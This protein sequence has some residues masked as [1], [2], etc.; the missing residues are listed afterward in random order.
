ML[1]IKMIRKNP[2]LV[3]KEISKLSGDH[4]IDK[5]IELDEKRRNLLVEVEE[6][7]A[8]QNQVSKE[9]PKMKKEGKD[10]SELLEEMKELSSN[11]KDIDGEVKEIDKD[12]KKLLLGIPNIP[13]ESVPEGET[14]EDNVE[15]RK[16]GQPTEFSFEPKAH[17]D[18]GVE[19]NILDFERA[20]KITGTRFSIFRNKGAL[21]QRALI[22][23]MLD[24]H[25]VDQDYIEMLTPFMVNRSSMTGTGQLPKFEEDAFSIPSKD[26]FLVP[27]A[28]VPVTNLHRDE[29]LNEDILPTYY[30]AY[31]PC[32]RQEAGSAGRDTR[33]LIRNHQFDKVELVKFSKPEDSYEELEKL[34]NDAEEVLKKLG[35]PYRVVNL[36][37]GD[38]GFSAAKTY[39]IEVWMP[40]YNRYVEISSCSNFEDFQ[41]RRANIRFRRKENKKLE[42]VHTLNGSGLAVG[43]TFA[44]LIENY[45]QEDGSILIPEVLRPY[46]R[47]IEK[48]T[49]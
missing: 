33:G 17:W 20:S 6:K 32:F 42:Y 40:S 39:D 29:I 41:A 21:L 14:D 30:T 36:C 2:E 35:L 19:L 38:L 16:W 28:E 15:I 45:Q 23:F 47:G 11:I 49:K 5:V 1:D 34:T 25:T 4:N 22:N 46:M 3:K 31:T 48:I 44:A 18:L 12:L 13:H 26:Y 10:I 37:T 9:I 43:R 27:T 24:L 8:K 7:K